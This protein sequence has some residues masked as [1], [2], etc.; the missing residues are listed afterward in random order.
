[1]RKVPYVD[2]S[3]Q[4]AAEKKTIL[5]T[6]DRTL[7]GGELILGEEVEAFEKGFAKICRTRFALGVANGTDALVMVLRALGVGPGDEVITAPNSFVASASAAA[8]VGATPRFCDVGP[9]QLMDPK[10]LKKAIPKR[11]K[12]IIPVHLTGRVCK[13]DE[14]NRIAKKRG[15]FVIEDAA[16]AVGAAYKGRKSGSF[17][18]AGCFSLHPLKNLNAA[19]D[20]GVIVSDNAALIEKLK[21]MRNHG[22]KNRNEVSFWGYNSRLDNIQAAILNMRLPGLAK[23][24]AA[25]RKN[26]AFYRKAL[27]GLEQFIQVPPDAKGDVYH[28]FVIQADRRDELQKFLREQG[29]STAVH[30]PTPIHLQPAARK[31]GY[32]K[33][34]F[35]ECERQ[36]ARILSLP[37]HQYLT[38]KQ[39]K[40]VADSIRR[41]Y[42][43]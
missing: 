8:L 7:S 16:Q 3:A 23:V 22:L 12:A 29:V 21:L 1:M 40:L 27:A 9:D 28:L 35:P 41:F 10:A 17:G 34:D 6:L 13:M 30:Y 18:V 15:L 2:F 4:Y 11:T 31:L 43:A 38:A 20:A 36:S 42:T 5:S 32:K 24:Q 19:G 33:G 25:R 37:I 26:A 14:I 39:L